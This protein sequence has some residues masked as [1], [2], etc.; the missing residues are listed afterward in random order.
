[1]TNIILKE[2]KKRMI[3]NTFLMDE[4]NPENKGQETV[5]T[6]VDILASR[7]YTIAQVRCLFNNILRRLEMNMPI[8]NGEV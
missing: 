7:N 1:M 3:P 5:D 4:M 8:S 6:I 2:V